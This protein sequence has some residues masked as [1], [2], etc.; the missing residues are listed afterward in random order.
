MRLARAVH[1]SLQYILQIISLSCLVLPVFLVSGFFNLNQ[2]VTHKGDIHNKLTLNQQFGLDQQPPLYVIGFKSPKARSYFL[3]PLAFIRA[4]RT[5]QMVPRLWSPQPLARIEMLQKARLEHY[6]PAL[7]EQLF[8]DTA[9]A[10]QRVQ[11][12]VRQGSFDGVAWP[13]KRGKH[14]ATG[15]KPAHTV[16]F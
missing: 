13:T 4:M 15:R 12:V 6:C 7:S 8:E 11:P 16:S 5:K 10:A 14:P 2:P 3:P 9:L 1:T